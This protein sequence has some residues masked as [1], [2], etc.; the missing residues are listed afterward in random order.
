ML[1]ICLT[2]LIIKNQ[3]TFGIYNL[4]YKQR[5]GLIFSFLKIKGFAQSATKLNHFCSIDLTQKVLIKAQNVLL[6]SFPFILCFR[7]YS[8]FSNNS[9]FHWS[10][11]ILEKLFFNKTIGMKY[12]CNKYSLNTNHKLNNFYIFF[13][14]TKAHDTHKLIATSFGYVTFMIKITRNLK[15]NFAFKFI[16]V[17]TSYFALGNDIQFKLQ[18]KYIGSFKSQKKYL[19]VKQYK[20]FISNVK[21]QEKIKKFKNYKSLIIPVSY[22]IQIK[23]IR[24]LKVNFQCFNKQLSNSIHK[25]KIMF[26]RFFPNLFNQMFCLFL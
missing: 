16:G 7:S 13:I 18:A 5:I 1:S 8:T 19:F 9:L 17:M 25:K 12:I 21:Y 4:I 2:C 3:A 11:N 23:F 20:I 26:F 15:I 24:F 6:K 22:F 10:F 14:L